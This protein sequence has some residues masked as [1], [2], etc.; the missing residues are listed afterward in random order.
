M[1][2]FIISAAFANK[3]IPLDTTFIFLEAYLI[4]FLLAA[5]KSPP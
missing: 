5:F 2:R 4:V 1:T 3:P